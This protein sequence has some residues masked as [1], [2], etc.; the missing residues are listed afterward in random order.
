MASVRIL[1]W[2]GIPAQV[3]ASE[4][5]QRAVSV[6]LPDWFSQEIDRIA[7]HDGLADSDAY[8]AAWEWSAPVERPGSPAQVA[9]DLAHE[10]AMA[11]GHPF[12][13]TDEARDSSPIG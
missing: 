13:V 11:H 2:K 10:L 6:A 3:K 1:A 4:P 12:P 5:G 8:L 7:M 9:N